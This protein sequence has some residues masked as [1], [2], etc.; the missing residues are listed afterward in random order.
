MDECIAGQALQGPANVPLHTS[1]SSEFEHPEIYLSHGLI[2]LALLAVFTT[3]NINLFE[4]SLLTPNKRFD[5]TK[6]LKQFC[7][8]L[9]TAT[10]FPHII[11]PYFVIGA[12]CDPVSKN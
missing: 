11:S 3:L 12:W 4:T 1:A 5:R 7:Q 10:A 6:I 8:L 2:S 9:C